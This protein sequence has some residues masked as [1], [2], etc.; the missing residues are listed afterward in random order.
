MAF[1][2]RTYYFLLT[3]FY[4]LHLAD[5]PNILASNRLILEGFQA[6]KSEFQAITRRAIARFENRDWA[7]I[8][9][10]NKERLRV[11]KK[12]TMEPAMKARRLLQEHYD[13]RG[14]W[15]ILKQAYAIEAAPMDDTE[16]AESFFNSVCRKVFGGMGAEPDFM[17]V[18]GA[19]MRLDVESS[20]PIFWEYPLRGTPESA[21]RQVMG[22]FPFQSAYADQERDIQ[23]ISR[24]L[25]IQSHDR[26]IDKHK[27]RLCAH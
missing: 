14:L 23:R 1:C 26:P 13:N 10:D 15:N 12:K 4:S 20:A 24:R 11:Y 21:I 6:Y 16:V 2:L 22:D 17:F 3:T 27:V 9:Q 18:D 25:N 5:F 19:I 8:Q 7:G